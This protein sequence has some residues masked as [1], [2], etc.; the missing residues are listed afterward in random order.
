MMGPA[1]KLLLLLAVHP[2]VCNSLRLLLLLLAVEGQDRSWWCSLCAFCLQDELKLLGRNAL[3]AWR[4]KAC[5]TSAGE[6]YSCT[7]GQ[8]QRIRSM[9]QATQKQT[10]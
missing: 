2:A 1:S 7:A 6:Q 10:F 9:H 5:M 4:V 8:E 3:E